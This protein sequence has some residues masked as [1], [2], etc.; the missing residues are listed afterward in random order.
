MLVGSDEE[1][2][3]GGSPGSIGRYLLFRNI[4][5]PYMTK[6]LGL[7]TRE[8]S[9]HVGERPTHPEGYVELA[10]GEGYEEP[11][12]KSTEPVRYRTPEKTKRKGIDSCENQADWDK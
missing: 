8:Q 3:L 2:S 6:E 5:F 1:N 12:H 9:K 10:D 7:R 4:M 11:T